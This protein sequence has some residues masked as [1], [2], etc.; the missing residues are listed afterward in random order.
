MF[1]RYRLPLLATCGTFYV[2]TRKL[3]INLNKKFGTLIGAKSEE[4]NE[5]NEIKIVGFVGRPESV[6]IINYLKWKNI[7]F[8]FENVNPIKLDK[9]PYSGLHTIILHN[10]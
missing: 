7:N 1:Y 2:A 5:I 8:S 6:A 9:L 3:E 4:K 10:I